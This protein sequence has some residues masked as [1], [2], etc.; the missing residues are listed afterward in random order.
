MSEQQVEVLQDGAG[1]A[2]LNGNNRGIDGALDESGKDIGGERTGNDDCIDDEFGGRFVAERAGLALNR[3]L[4]AD[5][6]SPS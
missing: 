1:Q 3:Y 6:G 2:V 4:H 5:A